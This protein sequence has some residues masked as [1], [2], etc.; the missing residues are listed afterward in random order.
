MGNATEDRRKAAELPD[1]D[2]IRV[3]LNQHARIHDLFDEVESSRGEQRQQAFEELRA[4]LAMHETAEEMVLRPVTAKTAGQDVVDARNHE[5]SEA[6][7]VL[8]ELEKLEVSSADF[9]EKLADFHTRRPSE[10]A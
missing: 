2:V 4:L 7:E 10:I 1:G 6:N 9:D 8:E 3:L 5:E